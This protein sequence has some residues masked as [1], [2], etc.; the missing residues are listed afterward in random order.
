MFRASSVGNDVSSY[1][2]LYESIANGDSLESKAERFEWGFLILCKYLSYIT[3][4]SQALLIVYGAFVFG[5][6]GYFIH[7]FSFVPWISTLIFFCLYF[8]DTLSVMRQGI[9]LAV[10]LI[11]FFYLNKGKILRHFCWAIFAALFHN[12][13]IVFWVAYP[14]SIINRYSKKWKIIGGFVTCGFIIWFEQIINYVFMLFPKYQYYIDTTYLDG[15]IR[16]GTVAILIITFSFY[17]ISYLL[18]CCHKKEIQ[19]LIYAKK[20]V[21]TE[22]GANAISNLTLLSC[23]IIA[24]S[25]RS[26]IIERFADISSIFLIVYY[27]NMLILIRNKNIRMLA[28]MFFMLMII[29]YRIAILLYRP[30]WGSTYPYSFF[31]EE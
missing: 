24:C 7:K 14:L 30:E 5:T 20:Q 4:D 2:N 13:A 28:N 1:V 8:D 26:T 12:A 15:N 21:L 19:E 16:L 6:I 27:P 22:R 31:W 11:S 29:I 17:L 23:L 3:E 25:F 9:A 18:D 10:V